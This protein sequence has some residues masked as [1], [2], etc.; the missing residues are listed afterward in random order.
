M[1]Q[2]FTE[3]ARRVIFFAQEEAG[4]LGESFVDTE[5]I[6]LGL[7]REDDSVAVR[8]LAR[9]GVKPKAV[10]SELEGKLKHG[11]GA[12]GRDM[13]LT[14]KAKDCIDLAYDEARRLNNNYIGTEHV[15]LGLLG[16][17]FGLTTEAFRKFGVELQ[18]TRG[19]VEELQ[20][21]KTRKGFPEAAE[22]T[23]L[24]G[25]HVGLRGGDLLDIA[26]LTRA[27]IDAIFGLSAQLKSGAIS[28]ADQRKIL[29]GKTMAMI[30]EKPSLRTR[31][32]FETGMFQL[33]GMAINL[34]PGDISLGQRESIADAARNF[35]RMVQIIMARVFDHS[36]V[37]ELAEYAKVPVINGLSDLEHP[38]QALADFFTIFEHKGKLEGLKLAF[39]GDGN[40]VAHSLVLLAAK[41]GM[42][43]AIACPEGYEPSFEIVA[44]ARVFAE[45]TGAAIEIVR[46][47]AQAA[48][49]ADAIYTDVWASMGQEAE[50]EER[51]KT[52]E[53][54]QVN[55]DLMKHAKEDAIFMHCLPAHRGSEVT[56]EVIDS[57]QSVVF[58]EA[59]NRLHVQKA[60]M[61]L[62]AG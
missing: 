6:L 40:N 39:I 54:Y 35:E 13:Q 45:E 29:E 59:E 61:A 49:G 50:Q 44:A 58:D 62:L 42:N 14:P 25:D 53:N 41:V 23:F 8:V 48:E 34:Q 9:M 47:P 51:A 36:T 55:A 30:F 24:E 31:V 60:V 28:P 3:R 38:C 57:P 2:R 5:H 56:D 32:S 4:R 19:I 1:W 43:F 18:R 11:P 17:D 10:R 22:S 26:Q 33:G 12:E 16:D 27:Q 21:N 37:T 7:V 15:L 46:D 20:G 52:F